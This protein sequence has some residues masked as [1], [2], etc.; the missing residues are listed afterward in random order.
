[1]IQDQFWRFHAISSPTDDVQ[2]HYAISFNALS[3]GCSNTTLR[4][5]GF[6][7]WKGDT[8]KVDNPIQFNGLHRFPKTDSISDCFQVALLSHDP[9]LKLLPLFTIA[10]PLTNRLKKDAFIWTSLTQEA[11]FKLKELLGST[12]VLRLPDFSKPFLVEKDAFG[13]G[14]KVVHS[15]DSH[16][17]AYFNHKLSSPKKKLPLISEQCFPSLRQLVNGYNAWQEV[18]YPNR[19]TVTLKSS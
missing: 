1:M 17:T 19:P 9:P 6:V 3:G 10:S 4:F 8:T 14:I 15:Q 18:P 12:L 7:I 13:T 11:F 2:T 16:P 5:I